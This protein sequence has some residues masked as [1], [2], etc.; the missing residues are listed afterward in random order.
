MSSSEHRDHLQPTLD[1]QVAT[2]LQDWI[3]RQASGDAESPAELIAKH[4]DLD[5][6][7][8]AC[9]ESISMLGS[10]QSVVSS[11]IKCNAPQIP[12]FEIVAE[13]GRGGMGIV[14]QANQISLGRTVALKVLP[15]AT[16]DPLAASRFQRE[17]ETAAALHH[18]NIV[19]IYAV[20]QSSGIHWFAM[21]RIDGAPLDHLLRTHPHG[22]DSDE[23]ARIGIEAA[24]ALAHAHRCGI[25]HR[26]I[27]PSN[28]MIESSGRVWLTDFGLARRELD[29]AATATGALV[30][31]PRYMSPEQVYASPDQPLDCRSD[32]YSLGATLYEIATGTVLFDGATPLDVLQQIR[33]ADPPRPRAVRPGMPRDL[34]VV[35]QKC[36]SKRP[37]DRYQRAEDL[38]SDLR[39]IR[40]GRPIQARGVPLWTVLRRRAARHRQR[41]KLAATT[42]AA[43][44]MMILLGTMLWFDHQTSRLGSLKVTAAGGPYAASIY[45]VAEDGHVDPEPVMTTTVPMQQPL[46]LDTGQYTMR[47]AGH[48]RFSESVQFAIAAGILVAVAVEFVVRAAIGRVT[49]KAIVE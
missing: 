4:P 30:G 13:L 10:A 39:A 15:L 26:D 28:L 1:L 12:D 35:L 31:T 21:Q 19:P 46:D 48:N 18:T 43:T 16:A 34:E 5:P 17:A 32:I 29:V 44:A 40:E 9:L 24:D 25:I 3:D 27:K 11:P 6:D 37:A 20:G 42:I 33:T 49:K 41:I 8:T 45:S 36:L 7:L 22:V 14:Y 23:V 2:V 47:L 38:V